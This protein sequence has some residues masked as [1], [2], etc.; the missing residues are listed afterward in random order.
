MQSSIPFQKYSTILYT[1]P[2]SFF[3]LLRAPWGPLDSGLNPESGTF[4][5]FFK[6]DVKRMMCSK[7]ALVGTVWC[8]W[9]PLGAAGLPGLGFDPG[10]DPGRRWAPLGTVGRR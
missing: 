3:R 8:R 10:F 6:K 2:S 1:I 7:K 9:A 5:P 4:L